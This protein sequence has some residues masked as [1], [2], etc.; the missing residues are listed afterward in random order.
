[1]WWGVPSLRR[2]DRGEAM[3]S[4]WGEE[5]NSTVA[6]VS[7]GFEGMG[8]W[9]EVGLE[10]IDTIPMSV[11]VGW[12]GSMDGLID[13]ALEI[14]DTMPISGSLDCT[15]SMDGLIDVGLEIVLST[16]VSI[17]FDGIDGLGEVPPVEVKLISTSFRS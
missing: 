12:T 8:S 5:R 16:L 11:S 2:K 9:I 14:I 6:V 15:G 1:M 13:V 3:D 7:W 17:S 10:I 4:D